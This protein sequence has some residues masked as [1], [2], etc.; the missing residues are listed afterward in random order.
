MDLKNLVQFLKFFNFGKN[1]NNYLK[2]LLNI[3]K[4][5]DENEKEQKKH[6]KNK[7]SGIKK[8]NYSTNSNK[9]NNNNDEFYSKNDKEDASYSLE[10]ILTKR[11]LMGILIS[12]FK[13]F[14][15]L[16]YFFY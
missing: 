1:D 10:N 16:S 6:N 9:H 2:D 13:I 3:L 8:D 15:I 7:Q 11:D 4:S 12:L 5:D 14:V